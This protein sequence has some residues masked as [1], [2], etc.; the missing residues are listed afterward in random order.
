MLVAGALA[1]LIFVV[2]AIG[3]LLALDLG[4]TEHRHWLDAL[5]TWQQ[6]IGAVLGFLGAA[7]VLVLS[8]AISQDN[9]LKKSAAAAHAIGLGLAYEVQAIGVGLK[10]AQVV[11]HADLSD[12]DP[13]SKCVGYA[14]A[15]KQIEVPATPVYDAVLPRM[16]DFGDTNLHDFVTF[17]SL[18]SNLFKRVPDIITDRCSDTDHAGDWL[19]FMVGQVDNMMLY[20]GS[21]ATNYGIASADLGVPQDAASQAASSA[22]A[23]SAPGSASG[24]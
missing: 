8:T 14:T 15:L 23:F 5:K 21:I 7:G 2:A 13:G 22:D 1:L 19:A 9:D 11:G 24:G 10:A 20:Y 3:S 18:Y 12:I 16:V 6:L 4:R 17:Y